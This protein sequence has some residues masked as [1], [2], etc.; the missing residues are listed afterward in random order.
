MLQKDPKAIESKIGSYNG[1]AGWASSKAQSAMIF[2]DSLVRSS[3]GGLGIG[4][5]NSSGQAVGFFYNLFV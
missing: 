4:S 1:L 5:Y 2:G 3:A